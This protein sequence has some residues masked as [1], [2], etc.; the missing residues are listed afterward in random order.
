MCSESE[1]RRNA[2]GYIRAS[3]AHPDTHRSFAAQKETIEQWALE[4]G[5]DVVGWYV[6]EGTTSGDAGGDPAGSD[7]DPSRLWELLADA[8]S[9]GRCFDTVLV[10]SLSRL[11]RNI[12]ESHAV[13]S[14]LRKSGVTVVSVS[15]PDAPTPT[16]RLIESI[17]QTLDDFQ[18]ELHAED[19]RR[20]IEAARRRREGC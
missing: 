17:I 14:E 10:W 13:K 7:D 11:S 9:S 16:D 20:G 5:Y 2:A 6:D 19:T 15:E 4:N 18:R 12:V 8:G 1:N 3:S